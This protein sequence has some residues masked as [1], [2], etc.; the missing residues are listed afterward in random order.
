M[1]PIEHLSVSSLKEFLACPRKFRLRRID[2]LVP[3]F[4]PVA[5][6]FGTAFHEAIAFGLYLHSQG[7]APHSEVTTEHFRQQLKK[8]ISS[9]TVPVLYD[10]QEDENSLANK[11]VEMLEAF[12]NEVPRPSRVLGIEQRFS[13]PIKGSQGEK[14]PPLIGSLDAAVEVDHKPVVWELK[15]GK[16]RWSEDKLEFD[17]QPTAYQLAFKAR[18]SVEPELQLAVVTKTKK[19]TVQLVKLRRSRADEIELLETAASVC[20]ALEAGVD[21]PQRSWACKTCEF[22]ESCR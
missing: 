14:L 4:R 19:P 9:E 2:G 21:H 6:A 10:D 22:A 5:L 7:Q 17:F 3:Q 15:S 16:Q 1:L 20:R 18:Y 12:W 13:L 11:G 8:Q